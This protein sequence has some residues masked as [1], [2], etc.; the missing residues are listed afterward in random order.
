MGLAPST[1]K[2]ADDSFHPELSPRSARE[3]GAGAVN[4]HKAKAW[5]V[6]QAKD[7]KYSNVEGAAYEYPQRIQYGRQ[8]GVGD[9]L[10]ALRPSHDAPDGR[11]IVGLGRIGEISSDGGDRLVARF[12]RYLKLSSPAT[13]DEIGG[14]PRRNQT[15]SIN[16]LDAEVV[17]KLLAREGIPSLVKTKK[18]K[19]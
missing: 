4:D 5:L 2:K 13:F 11:R 19:L 7:S 16:P 1:M 15:I 8:I 3:I 14:D 9:V 6:T 17:A 10:V 18:E 12:D